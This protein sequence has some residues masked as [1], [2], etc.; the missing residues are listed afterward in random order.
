MGVLPNHAPLRCVLEPGIVSCRKS[1]NSEEIFA[2]STGLAMIRNDEVV[3]MADA[4]ERGDQIDLERARA[5]EQRARERL[6]AMDSSIDIDRAEIALKRALVR[7]QARE[8][9][10]SL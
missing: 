8:R 7:M 2:V 10:E 1:D 9:W 4:A 5:S 6:H 3:V